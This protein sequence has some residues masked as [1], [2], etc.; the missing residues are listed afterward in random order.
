M[1]R[2]NSNSVSTYR[3][4]LDLE[5][6]NCVPAAVKLVLQAIKRAFTVWNGMLLISFNKMSYYQSSV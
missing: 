4:P 1:F 3:M 5:I 6:R 2:G